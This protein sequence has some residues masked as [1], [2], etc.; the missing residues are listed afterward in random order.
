M[1]Q[2]FQQLVT[3]LTKTEEEQK[4]VKNKVEKSDALVKNLSSELTRWE[5]S[6][7]N[8][9]DDMASLAGDVLLSSGILTYIGFFDHY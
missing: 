1:Q 4:T 3:E 6:S 9:K 5:R 8:F 7:L 2:E